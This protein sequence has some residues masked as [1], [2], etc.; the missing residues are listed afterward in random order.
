[1]SPQADSRLLP[2]WEALNALADGELAPDEQRA[3]AAVLADSPQAAEA[4]RGIVHLKRELRA[5]PEALPPPLPARRPGRAPSRWPALAAALLICGVGLAALLLQREPTGGSVVSSALAIHERFAASPA[6][7]GAPAVSAASGSRF[8][9]ELAGVGL[10]PVW[11]SAGHDGAH[12]GFIGAHGC[13]V[14]LH[15]I[16]GERPLQTL[17]GTEDL[18]SASW[19]AGNRTYLLIASGMWPS[20]FETLR[21]LLKAL[22]AHPQGEIAPLRTAFLENW[23]QSPSCAA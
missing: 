9:A 14:S 20:R 17:A 10:R 7:E 16:D 23:G 18:A 5:L 1:M 15:V 12:M 2:E 22:T 3:L 13:R 21:D 19:T 11:A 4:L 8:A 6:P